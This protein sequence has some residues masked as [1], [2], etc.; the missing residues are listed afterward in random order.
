M[1]ADCH[2][3]ALRTHSVPA[4]LLRPLT[5]YLLI[6]CFEVT[7]PARAKSATQRVR[8]Y[9]LCVGCLFNDPVPKSSLRRSRR[10]PANISS[11]LQM[12]KEGR[13]WPSWVM[14]TAKGGRSA[15]LST[16]KCF[17]EYRIADRGLRLQ[18][19]SPARTLRLWV[20]M[21]CM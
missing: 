8:H 6:G 12:E 5:R 2:V 18:L 16:P 21:S 17:A 13:G 19:S 7:Q 9:F 20:R 10:F 11:V 1:T 4:K 15:V 3:G 14:P